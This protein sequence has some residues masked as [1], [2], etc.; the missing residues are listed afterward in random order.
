MARIGW[1]PIHILN[2]VSYS[3]GSVLKPAGL[4]NA[5]GILS[6]AFSKD[7]TDPTWTD[8]SGYK[9]GSGFMDK[10]SPDADRTS[11]YTVVSY[12]GAETLVQALKQCGDDLT[13]AN[14]MKQAA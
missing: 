7:P 13:R 11:S 9:E 1:K 10:W 2:N 14:V 8:D 12:L 5:R 4:E 6:T 3:V